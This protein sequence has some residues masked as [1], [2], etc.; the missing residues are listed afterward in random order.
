MSSRDFT[1]VNCAVGASIRYG[2]QVAICS[3]GNLS[4]RGMYLKTGYEIPLDIP[5]HV[6]VYN[7]GLSSFKV[8]AR[9]VWRGKNGVGLQI[10]DLDVDSFVQLRDFIAEQNNDQGAILQETYKMLKCI[11]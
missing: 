3:T 9:V 2:N 7:S 11:H 1:R 6:T 5:A 8:N 10:T 4:L